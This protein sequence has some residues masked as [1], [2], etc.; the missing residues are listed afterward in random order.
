MGKEN[1]EYKN[2][3][4][5]YEQYSKKNTG[6]KGYDNTL[7]MA[8]K[9]A[10]STALGLQSQVQT[11]ARNSGMSRSA[12]AMMGQNAM[13]SAY[14]NAFANQQQQAGQQLGNQLN[15]QGNLMNSHQAEGQNEFNR[16]WGAAANAVGAAGELIGSAAKIIPGK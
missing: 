5:L 13:S 3:A 14:N 9:G 10:N 6:K 8:Q 11:A 2:A 15:A 12:A 1:T 4:S 7:E 16:G